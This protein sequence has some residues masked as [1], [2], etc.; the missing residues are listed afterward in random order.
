MAAGSDVTS[1][2]KP[3]ASLAD[4]SSGV[5]INRMPGLNA[6]MTQAA[7]SLGAAL[8]PLL[9]TAPKC[10]FDGLG[11]TTVGKYILESRHELGLGLVCAELDAQV[12]LAFDRRTPGL[13]PGC[14]IWREAR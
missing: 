6:L 11:P 4:P 10:R 5:A 2:K 12:L 14:H 9:G 8:E 7:S 1:A 3:G 13:S